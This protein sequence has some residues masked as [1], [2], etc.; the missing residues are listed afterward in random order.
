MIGLL[1]A[2]LLAAE[3]APPAS[4]AP[5]AESPGPVIGIGAQNELISPQAGASALLVAADWHTVQGEATVAAGVFERSTA[6]GA[7]QDD[8]LGFGARVYARVHRTER[9][10]LALGGGGSVAILWSPSPQLAWTV[11]T[12]VRV[13]IFVVPNAALTGSLGA[14]VVL[15]RG[16]NFFIL[17]ARPLGSAGFVYYFR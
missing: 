7:P 12:G 3:P 14:G 8:V 16:E 11:F 4:A 17:G 5:P 2:S 6:N 13:R 9:S 1:L 10:D 15:Q